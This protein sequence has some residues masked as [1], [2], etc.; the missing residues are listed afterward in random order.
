NRVCYGKI[1]GSGTACNISVVVGVEC[2]TKAVIVSIPSQIRGKDQ[3]IPGCVQLGYKRIYSPATVSALN[4]I[5]EG[6]VMRTGVACHVAIAGA[7]NGNPSAFRAEDKPGAASSQI[8]G[9]TQSTCRVQFGHKGI[10]QSA[11]TGL[12]SVGG[13]KVG[14]ERATGYISVAGGVDGDGVSLVQ[15]VAAKV[16]GINEGVA[17]RA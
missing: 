3:S 16:S 9:V 1:R 13:R 2:D 6:K 7:V 11:E 8:G 15:V 4:G 10:A 5:G 17:R 12:E 14:G